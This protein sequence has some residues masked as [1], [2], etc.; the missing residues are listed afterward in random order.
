V[1]SARKEVRNIKA[2][3]ESLSSHKHILPYLATVSIGEDLVILSELATIDLQNFLS[4]NGKSILTYDF[5]DLVC[6]T[7]NIAGALAFLHSGLQLPGRVV[8]FYLMDLK[9]DNILLFP[10]ENDHVGIWKISDFGISTVKYN[11]L[12]PK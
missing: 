1:L 7:R 10:A 12:Q 9:P 2:L 11:S 8:T 6:Q 5:A 4:G 3:R